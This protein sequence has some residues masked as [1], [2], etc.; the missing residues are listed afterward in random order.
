MERVGFRI[1]NP[2]LDDPNA[3][4]YERQSWVSE[5][6]KDKV[7]ND[8]VPKENEYESNK[9]FRAYMAVPEYYPSGYYS[10]SMM[11]FYD[12]ANNGTDTYFVRDTSDYFIDKSMELKQ[13]K[14]VRDSI[15]VETK[16]PDYVKPE[17]DINFHFHT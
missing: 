5:F 14:D 11:N 3:Q 4:V 1:I 7:V 2:T 15:Y 6:Y 16:Y 13:F 9:F 10:I 12:K 17:I 8:D